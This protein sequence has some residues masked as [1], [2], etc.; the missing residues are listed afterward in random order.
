[1]RR[2]QRERKQVKRLGVDDA[3]DDEPPRKK[4][5]R[6]NRRANGHVRMQNWSRIKHPRERSNQRDNQ[7]AHS[8]EILQLVIF[9]LFPFSFR[10]SFFIFPP[11]P[12][13]IK[14]GKKKKLKFFCI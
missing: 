9:S 6:Q 3:S 4:P 10:C 7:K 2:S 5:R 11:F 1:M 8:V 14:K 12:V 13:K